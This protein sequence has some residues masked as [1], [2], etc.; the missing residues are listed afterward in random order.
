MK[1][2][3]DCR[4]AIKEAPRNGVLNNSSQFVDFMR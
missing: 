2:M 4:V 3:G 1:L